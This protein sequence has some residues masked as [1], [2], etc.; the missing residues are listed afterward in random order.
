MK[1]IISSFLKNTFY[2]GGRLWNEEYRR[3]ES[4]ILEALCLMRKIDFCHQTLSRTM[5]RAVMVKKYF[6]IIW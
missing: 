6:M 5:P 3:K 4:S 2:G 1:H